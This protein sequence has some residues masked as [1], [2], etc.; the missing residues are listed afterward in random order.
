MGSDFYKI[1]REISRELTILG[2]ADISEEV[3]LLI[4]GGS[5]GTEILMGLRWKFLQFLEENKESNLPEEIRIKIQNL[6]NEI[7]EILDM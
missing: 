7:S 5:T 1:S 2:W 4:S 3:E 6:I